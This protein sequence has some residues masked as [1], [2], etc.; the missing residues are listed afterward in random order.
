MWR[1][2]RL[3][4]FMRTRT[5]GLDRLGAGAGSKTVSRALGTIENHD[6]SPE[7]QHGW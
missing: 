3:S 4:Q 2:G 1:S 7:T 6:K 5:R